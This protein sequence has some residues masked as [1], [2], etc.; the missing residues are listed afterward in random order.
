MAH[1]SG[2]RAAALSWYTL[3]ILSFIG[4]SHRADPVPTDLTAEEAP[5][6]LTWRSTLELP[7][8]SPSYAHP[9]ASDCSAEASDDAIFE[10]AKLQFWR[11]FQQDVADRKAFWDTMNALEEKLTE[12]ADP[13]K[14]GLFIFHRAQLAM[15]YMLEHMDTSPGSINDMTPEDFEVLTSMSADIEAA[16]LLDPNEPFYVT[17]LDTL[18]IAMAD[19]LGQQ[20]RMLEA[21]D[22]A[23]LN[24]ENF[25]EETTRST[26]VASLTGTTI[27][28][29]IDS[30][31]PHRTIELLDTFACHPKRLMES[32]DAVCGKGEDRR[33]CVEWCLANSKKAPFG[34]PGLMYHLGESYARM[35]DTYQAKQIY[36]LALTLPG[37]DEWP[38]RSM[39]EEALA[40]MDSHVAPFMNLK[41]EETASY[42]VYANSPVACQL[43]HGNP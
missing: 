40:D 5:S 13:V 8:G 29:S 21:V 11:V 6:Y 24:V 19:R 20:E 39:V 12:S 3:I 25:T 1:L 33:S 43:C 41:D 28:L 34:G 18:E 27:G 10:C 15:T 36:E 9:E 4:C 30:G 2:T 7:E 26:L 16:M 35:G 38:H 14:K 22:A 23:M 17:W 32:P 42:V 37:A 31:A